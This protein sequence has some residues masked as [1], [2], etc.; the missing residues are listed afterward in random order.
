MLVRNTGQE[1][2]LYWRDAVIEVLSGHRNDMK[3]KDIYR[4][5]RRYRELTNNDEKETFGQVNYYHKVRSILS[6]LV[7]EGTIERT[8]RA[9]YKL[10]R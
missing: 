2:H 8:D 6:V 4:E 9:A 3:L 10:K 5:V 7:K 1:G